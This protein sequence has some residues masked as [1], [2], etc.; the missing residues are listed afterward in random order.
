MLAL[1]RLGPTYPKRELLLG[2]PRGSRAAAAIAALPTTPPL[3]SD[4]TSDAGPTALLP[5]V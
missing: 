2:A 1:P 4:E 5:V 3:P